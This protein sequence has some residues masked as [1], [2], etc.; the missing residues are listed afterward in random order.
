MR[1]SREHQEELDNLPAPF[2]AMMDRVLPSITLICD[3]FNKR[4]L[5]NFAAFS[6]GAWIV[7]RAIE[8]IPD[9]IEGGKELSESLDAVAETVLRLW[10]ESEQMRN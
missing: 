1:L 2:R 3:D 5:H 9:E 8:D 10:Y 4:K 6:I 7:L